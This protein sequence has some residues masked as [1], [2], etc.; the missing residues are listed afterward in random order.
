MARRNYSA[1]GSA[2][3]SFV[4]LKGSHNE[5]FLET[6]G[7]RSIER[8]VENMMPWRHRHPAIPISTASAADGIFS[9]L[10][11]MSRS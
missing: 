7:K 2:K 9:F 3:K 5:G 11:N 6:G 10:S 8:R 4:D 1:S